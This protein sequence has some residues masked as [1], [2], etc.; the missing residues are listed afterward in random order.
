MPAY[1]HPA[2]TMMAAAVRVQSWMSASL[3]L[4][5][6]RLQQISSLNGARTKSLQK[7]KMDVLSKFQARKA[8]RG[9]GR[10]RISAYE[11]QLDGR[12]MQIW[13]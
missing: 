5:N 3:V 11:A 8:V 12:P 13:W 10:A 4:I 2:G 6:P 9:L 7:K 1:Q